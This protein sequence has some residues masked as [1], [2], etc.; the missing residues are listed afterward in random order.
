MIFI[1]IQ[2]VGVYYALIIY[3]NIDNNRILLDYSVYNYVFIDKIIYA[4][5]H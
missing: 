2:F 3:L 4:I 5:A 1:F